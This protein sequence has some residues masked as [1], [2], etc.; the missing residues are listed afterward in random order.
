MALPLAATRP[1]WHAFTASGFLDVIDSHAGCD[2]QVLAQ[3]A[4]PARSS[5]Y[6]GKPGAFPV[7]LVPAQSDRQTR[8]V[9]AK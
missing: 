6:W 1:R 2:A 3:A 5:R 7:A 4:A 8:F 9:P